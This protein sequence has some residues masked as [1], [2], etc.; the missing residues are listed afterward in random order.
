MIFKKAL[1]TLLIDYF[2]NNVFDK[3]RINLT[4]YK[5]DSKFE[6]AYNEASKKVIDWYLLN[7]PDAKSDI[8]KFQEEELKQLCYQ[9]YVDYNLQTYSVEELTL[10]FEYTMDDIILF[11]VIT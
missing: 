2:I 11:H 5:F 4:L 6:T 9:Y 10:D 1:K 7:Y 3:L 8:I